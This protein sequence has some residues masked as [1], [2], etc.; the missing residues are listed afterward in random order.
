MNIWY[1]VTSVS[2]NYY[3]SNSTSIHMYIEVKLFSLCIWVEQ[4]K[5][6]IIRRVCVPLFPALLT[7]RDINTRFVFASSSLILL[8]VDETWKPHDSCY[9]SDKL[10][11][12]KNRV[13]S[14]RVFRLSR[15]RMREREGSH[16][17][18]CVGIHCTPTSWRIVIR[19]KEKLECC[20]SLK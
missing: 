3:Y 7:G 8:A 20:N 16:F 14:H 10:Y 9:F 1:W 12:T 4:S 18:P 5:M 17:L 6:C 11:P 15:E 19:H 13:S 2:S